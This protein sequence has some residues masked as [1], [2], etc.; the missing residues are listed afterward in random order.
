MCVH[1]LP[2]VCAMFPTPLIHAF[3]V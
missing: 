1:K 2:V 3:Q